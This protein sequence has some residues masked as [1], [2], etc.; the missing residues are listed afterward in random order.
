MM[1]GRQKRK[2][3]RKKMRWSVEGGPEEQV[4]TESSIAPT[5]YKIVVKSASKVWVKFECKKYWNI[6]IQY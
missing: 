3:G 4:P 6:I 1:K 2:S 5:V